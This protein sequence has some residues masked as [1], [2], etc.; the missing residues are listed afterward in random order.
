MDLSGLSSRGIIGRFYQTL[1]ATLGDSWVPL[2]SMLIES[3]QESETYKWLGFSPALRE[4]VGG[5]Q[6]KGL[7]ENG[8]IL[9]HDRFAKNTYPCNSLNKVVI[10]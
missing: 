8:I 5:R 4:W 10:F 2:I 9:I 1:E 3:N 6:A 7:R